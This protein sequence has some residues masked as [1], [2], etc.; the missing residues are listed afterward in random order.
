MSLQA[1][2]ESTISRPEPLSASFVRQSHVERTSD[3]F[4]RFIVSDEAPFQLDN[5]VCK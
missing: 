3:F 2:I 5:Y 4:D 1:T